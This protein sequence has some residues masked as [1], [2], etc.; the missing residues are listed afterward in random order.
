MSTFYRLY[1][2]FQGQKTFKALDIN[3]GYQVSNLI[4][5]TLL[6]EHELPK[7][8]NL[9]ELNKETKFEIRRADNNKKITY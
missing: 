8:K 3:Q 5:A 7:V 4:Y 6:N 9:I 1:A 2:K